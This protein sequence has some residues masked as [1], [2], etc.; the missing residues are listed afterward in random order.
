MADYYKPKKISELNLQNDSKVAL[1][2]TVENILENSFVLN[3]GEKIEIAAENVPEK[4][5]KVRVF[6]SVLDQQLK[7]DIVQAFNADEELFA[8]SYEFSKKLGS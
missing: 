1:V 4:G 3:D 2:G 8:K 7:A 5:K 6:C